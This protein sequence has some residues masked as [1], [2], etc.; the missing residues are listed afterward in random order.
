MIGVLRSP[1]FADLWYKIIK[2]E[3][4]EIIAALQGHGNVL[5]V[6]NGAFVLNMI[7]L[8]NAALQQVQS[9]ASGLLGHNIKLPTITSAEL[10]AQAQE[11]LSKA[12]GVQVPSDFAQI[13]V[14]KGSNIEVAS[15]A[16]RAID[17]LTWL[18]PLVTILFIAAA[19]W[20]SMDRR[21]TLLQL[22]VLTFLLFVLTRRLAF[23]FEAEAIASAKP[24]NQG[25]A[26]DIVHQLT[27]SFFL[28]TVWV[29]VL[30]GIVTAVCLLAG[31]YA[32]ARTLR[33]WVVQAWHWAVKA[34]GGFGRS[35]SGA[36]ERSG[37]T[38]WVE[39]NR[40]W[41]QVGACVLAAILLFVLPWIGILIVIALFVIFEVLLWRVGASARHRDHEDEGADDT[42]SPDVGAPATR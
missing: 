1:L 24:S 35:L 37:T 26:S 21:R 17:L 7:P 9:G 14:M 8:V 15:F 4:Q 5:M 6:E 31:P 40:G 10:P 13:T 33:R 41:L 20:A 25:A 16:V 23:R 22:A 12:L 34:L 30:S 18:L 11:A 19:L 28:I 36:S 2:F 29:L 38:E 39:A 42:V 27:S 3:H 32:W